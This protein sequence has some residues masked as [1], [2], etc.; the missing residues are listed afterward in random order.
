[1]YSCTFIRAVGPPTRYLL[2]NF[3]EKAIVGLGDA[4][5]MLSYGAVSHF[6]SQ[7]FVVTGTLSEAE[8]SKNRWLKIALSGEKK[9]IIHVYILQYANV[10]S[11]FH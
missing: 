9:S 10:P 8:C 3:F 4:F 6:D 1:M 2:H 5:F 7:V 11:A